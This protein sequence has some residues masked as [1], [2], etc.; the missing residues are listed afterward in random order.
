MKAP[1]SEVIETLDRFFFLPFG[2]NEDAA[3]RAIAIEAYL[4][5]SGWTWNEVIEEMTKS[6]T[7]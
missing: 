3:S 5:A 2:P 6:K 7:N 4:E 1:Y